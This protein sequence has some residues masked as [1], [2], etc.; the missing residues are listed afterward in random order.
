MN[1]ELPN[2]ATARKLLLQGL[3]SLYVS[4]FLDIATCSIDW[5]ELEYL[6][7]KA[8]RDRGGG[9]EDIELG[10]ERYALH[11]YGKFPYRYVLSN[12]TFEVRLSEGLSPSCYVRFSSEGLWTD[13]ADT[14]LARFEE[15]CRSVDLRA[16]KPEVISRADWAFD[17][18]LPNAQLKPEQ[19]VS[20]AA[21]KATWEE[22]NSVQT[23]QCGTGAVVIRIYDKVAEIDQQ[24]LKV[25]LFELWGKR[26][27]VWRIEFQVR[28]ER[29]KQ[30][31]IKTWTDLK[32]FE[33]DLLREI[34]TAH[35][36]LREPTND[37]NRSRWPLH[38]LWIQLIAD[39]CRG[40]QTGLIRS[41]DE[42]AGLDWRLDRNGKSVL[43][44]LKQ[45][46]ALLQA[47]GRCSRPI[48]LKDTIDQMTLIVE[49]HHSEDLWKSDIERRVKAIELG[50]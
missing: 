16:L 23:I 13:G 17:Y 24:S 30:G 19:I 37:S 25:W 11:S 45:M 6:K 47:S 8:S 9:F 4:Y 27:D 50:Q 2:R 31:G 43:G 33:T 34:A 48:T 21:K 26:E 36:T 32:S 22:H 14:L 7:E 46:A 39:I 20:R 10:T 12:K 3:D 1:R 18:F 29:L 41:F 28:G 44:H 5:D 38:P 15:W 49:R 42:Q 35:T 40:S